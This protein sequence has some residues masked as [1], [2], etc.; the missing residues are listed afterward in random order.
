MN[1]NELN[2]QLNSDKKLISKSEKTQRIVEIRLQAP[3]TSTD[4]QRPKLN[5]ALVLDRSGSMAGDKLEHVKQ[6][7]KHVLDQLQ[8]HDKVA[9]V[10]YDNEIQVLSKSI[11][12]TNGNCFELKQLIS[13]IRSGNTTN[14][15]GGWLAGCKEIASAADEGS[16]NRTMLLTDGLANVGETDLEI[17]GQHAFELYKDTISTSTF[18]VGYGFN[19]HLLE[20][21]SNRGGGNFYFIEH[22]NEIR[23]I[24]LKEFEELVGISARRVEIRLELPAEVEWQVLGGWSSERKDNQL[25][26]YVGDMLSGRT[27]EIYLRLQVP[28]DENA[29]KLSLSAKVFGQGEPGQ[30]FEGIA[31]LDF[32]YDEQVEVEQAAEDRELVERYSQV[33]L[34]DAANEALKL[35]R[36]GKRE[37]ASQMLNESLQRSKPYISPQAASNYQDIS[38]KMRSGLDETHRKRY[39]QDNYNIKRRKEQ[40][41]D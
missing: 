18:G 2:I 30:V 38:N 27:Q 4:D 22:P 17:L 14:L 32:A 26:I 3:T 6:A 36:E 25:H 11:Q 21:M 13:H 1:K 20:A 24:F 37:R 35:E 31:E 5:L 23:S 9:L 19:E 40:Q 10:V 29:S 8:N 7:A 39:H 28:A 16:V 15:Y 12:V 41:E 34:A 33:E